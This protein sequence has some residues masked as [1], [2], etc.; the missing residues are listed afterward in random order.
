MDVASSLSPA[1]AV[2]ALTALSRE[3]APDARTDMLLIEVA[4]QT[5]FVRYLRDSSEPE[6]IALNALR[7][8]Y[9]GRIEPHA[10]GCILRGRFALPWLHIAMLL[11]RLRFSS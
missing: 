9:R 6:N 5:V 10:D 4:G 11:M 1:E 8:T 2:G 3:Y 7:C